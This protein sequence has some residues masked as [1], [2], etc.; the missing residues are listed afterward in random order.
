MN[1]QLLV[2][3]HPSVGRR[4]HNFL[5]RLGLNPELLHPFLHSFHVFVA[6]NLLRLHKLELT[7]LKHT[8]L[9]PGQY[10]ILVFHDQLGP[11]VL[12]LLGLHRLL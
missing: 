1:R 11:H 10:L 8:Q 7:L 5:P 9:L 6:E 4:M 12:L 3:I 2:L